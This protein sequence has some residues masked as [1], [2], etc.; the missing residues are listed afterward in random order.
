MQG[1][2]SA[3]VNI[4]LIVS[5]AGILVTGVLISN[6][7]FRELIPLTFRRNILLHQLHVSL[8]Y[9]WLI[10]AGLHLGFHWQGVWH[11]LAARFSLT[12][13][14]AAGKVLSALLPAVFLAAGI[15]S[16]MLNRAGDRL[17]MKHIFNTPALHYPLEL[18][19]LFFIAILGMYTCFGFMA[20]KYF[21]RKHF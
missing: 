8:P 15:W 6:H 20:E 1:R 2:L 5:T 11:R 14:P 19:M 4:L 9:Y 10:L 21:R 18:Y 3:V 7:L 17:L 12:I 16:S 13:S